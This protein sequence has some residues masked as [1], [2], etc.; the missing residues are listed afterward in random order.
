MEKLSELKLMDSLQEFYWFTPV[1][2]FPRYEDYLYAVLHNPQKVPQCLKY[3]LKKLT[4]AYSELWDCWLVSSSKREET[5]NPQLLHDMERIV[6][7]IEGQAP[8]FAIEIR[9]FLKE[10][11]KY[12][13]DKDFLGQ[14]QDSCN[15][16]QNNLKSVGVTMDIHSFMNG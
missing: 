11:Q 5:I 1:V 16:L 3:V 8:Q 6:I 12:P 9:K 13:T 15:I 14:V 10:S 2:Y 7:P 4:N